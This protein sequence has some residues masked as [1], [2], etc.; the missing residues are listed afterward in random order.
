MRFAV[1]LHPDESPKIRDGSSEPAESGDAALLDVTGQE[2]AA[3]EERELPG[4]A[5]KGNE[6]GEFLQHRGEALFTS[7]SPVKPH[8]RVLTSRAAQNHFMLSEATKY[9]LQPTPV[10]SSKQW[11][12]T[13]S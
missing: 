6:M 3:H 13:G 7:D 1:I 11:G 9:S 2:G 4:G 12:F 8:F 10:F 5:G